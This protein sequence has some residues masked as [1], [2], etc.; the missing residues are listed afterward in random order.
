MPF[1]L[2][3]HW[4]RNCWQHW[5]KSTVKGEATEEKNEW[6]WDS[7]D[8]VDG[9]EELETG[10]GDSDR[11]RADSWDGRR[12]ESIDPGQWA[13]SRFT[14]SAVTS[15]L[16]HGSEPYIPS[17]QGHLHLYM[18]LFMCAYVNMCLWRDGK[19]DTDT[20]GVC[21]LEIL[22]QYF[23]YRVNQSDVPMTLLF[24][25]VQ[26]ELL[27]I[28]IFTK[29]TA[30]TRKTLWMRQTIKVSTVNQQC[31]FHSKQCC[32]IWNVLKASEDTDTLNGSRPSV[33]GQLSEGQGS[34]LKALYCHPRW[35]NHVTDDQACGIS[36][37]PD[38]ENLSPV[39]P[40]CR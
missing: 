17:G 38:P 14:S 31:F 29:K 18:R 21:G 24:S 25:V 19:T 27:G 16:C 37:T 40:C 8:R 5:E 9:E 36:L 7:S 30:R 22:E 1:F 34:A 32:L 10:S 33:S 6:R 23:S 20:C 4:K 2:L 3:Y 13:G 35:P 26:W 28:D 39:F 11:E 15:A 12:G